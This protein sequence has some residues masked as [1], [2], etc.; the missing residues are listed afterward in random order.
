MR[1][2]CLSTV[3]AFTVFAFWPSS[4]FISSCLIPG[5]LIYIRL[6]LFTFQFVYI[7]RRV[8]TSFYPP[9]KAF[10]PLY[11]WTK[12]A[13]PCSG[14]RLQI[15]SLKLQLCFCNELLMNYTGNTGRADIFN[16]LKAILNLCTSPLNKTVQYKCNV[17]KWYIYSV[18]TVY[19][20]IE[21]YG[22]CN[23]MRGGIYYKTF[24]ISAVLQRCWIASLTVENWLSV[25]CLL[26]KMW[27]LLQKRNMSQ[28][29]S[30]ICNPLCKG[31]VVWGVVTLVYSLCAGRA[32]T[33][34]KRHLHFTV[35]C[36]KHTRV[37]FSSV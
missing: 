21:C 17:A 10:L 28:R 24:Q 7:P 13:R 27:S 35:R 34:T 26:S 18:Y 29:V 36:F 9:C 12:L 14:G 33:G 25:V 4:D 5:C 37:F 6:P 19:D 20:I 16:V 11:M 2:L 22:H 32:S 3:I 30:P 31:L 8:H 1:P 23:A 15:S